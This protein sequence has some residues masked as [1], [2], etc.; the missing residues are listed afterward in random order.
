MKGKQAIMLVDV[1]TDK[2]SLAT[3]LCR[4]P[5]MGATEPSYLRQRVQNAAIKTL[6]FS[7]YST[8]IKALK[9]DRAACITNRGD[10]VRPE[11]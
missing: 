5:F 8:P 10:A 2:A 9:R 3:W 6:G 1:E 4:T 7:L 11:P